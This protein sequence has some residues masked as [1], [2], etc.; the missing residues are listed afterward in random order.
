[1]GDIV[2][3]TKYHVEMTVEVITDDEEAAADFMKKQIVDGLEGV[4]AIKN[5]TIVKV[6]NEPPF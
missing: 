1:M 6:N 4:Q 5:L 2:K 3:V